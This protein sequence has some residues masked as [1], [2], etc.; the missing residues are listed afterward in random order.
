MGETKLWK[1]IGLGMMAINLVLIGF[2]WAGALRKEGHRPP[3]PPPLNGMP[4]PPMHMVADLNLNETQTEQF[5]K[6]WE[7]HFSR[8]NQI[9]ETAGAWRDSMWM[10]LIAEKPDT[11]K[12]NLATMKIG[13]QQVKL[14]QEMFRHFSEVK[15]ICTPQQAEAFNKTTREVIQ[16]RRGPGAHQPPPPHK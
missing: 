10:E 12:L 14:E 9:K 3:P 2:F 6:L 1:W 7:S 4:Q 16:H 8:M 5:I 13:E 15:A 11:S